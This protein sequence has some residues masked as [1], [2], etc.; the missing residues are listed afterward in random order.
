MNM[1]APE[2][3]KNLSH[4]ALKSDF[5]GRFDAISDRLEAVKEFIARQLVSG[6]ESVDRRLEHVA[7]TTGK[8]VRPALVLLCG[9]C[10]GGA[11]DLHVEIASIIEM[12]HLATLLHDDVIDH[13]DSRR[14]VETANSKWGNE[15]AVLLGDFV[16]SKAFAMSSRLDD[17]RI[18]SV[19]ADTAIRICAGELEQ[20]AQRDNW[21]LSEKE[22]FEI[23]EAKTASLF[24]I[25]CQLGAIAAGADE[26]TI[27]A[28]YDFGIC[29]GMAF[30]IAD[31][32]IDITGLEQGEGKTLG[33]DIAERKPTLPMIYLIGTLNI[34]EADRFFKGLSAGQIP[35][36]YE[37]MLD[38]CGS[39]E[40]ASKV[41]RDYCDRAID[42]LDGIDDGEAKVLLADIV[43]IVRDRA[44]SR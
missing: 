39:L 6:S 7:L 22:Y 34:G 35:D 9:K 8:M 1:P 15:S 19:L 23:I 33:R 12:V 37:E 4:K 25:S 20:N 24:G 36:N 42:C 38:G 18:S 41:A 2:D 17:S 21:R 32:L 43:R 44:F 10:C 14:S 13:A 29:L 27:K 16:L 3:K 11:G 26:K 28:F 30:Q 40:Y 5:A 31:D